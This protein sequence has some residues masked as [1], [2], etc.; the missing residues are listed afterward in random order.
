MSRRWTAR[1]ESECEQSRLRCATSWSAP[2]VRRGQGYTLRLSAVP[3]VH[4][5]LL[6]L[7]SRLAPFVKLARSIR[8]RRQDIANALTFKLTN[9]RVESM[10]TKIC[11]LIRRTYGFRAS[12]PYAP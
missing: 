12:P 1:G 8:S 2:H 4:R 7:N 5:G 9:A 6:D 11:L 10:N 3:T